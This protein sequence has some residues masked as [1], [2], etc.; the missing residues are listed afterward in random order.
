MAK[1]SEKTPLAI[2]I[3][4]WYGIIFSVTYFLVSV[5]SV[6][7]SILDRT[8]K[9]IDKNFLIGLY[10]IPILIISLGFKSGQKWGWFGYSIFLIIV[11]VW[12]VLK[13][14]DIYGIIIGLLSL[15]VLAGILAKPVRQRFFAA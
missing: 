10:G 8:Y 14:Q 11:I 2:R 7:L 3:L 9:D 15:I 5:V 1:E 13:Y 6:V 4:A 12:S